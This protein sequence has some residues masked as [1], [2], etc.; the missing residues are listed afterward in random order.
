MATAYYR[1]IC[2]VRE[3]NQLIAER[4]IR[5][6][7]SGT[8]YETWYTPTRYDDPLVAQRELALPS[9]II[10]EYRVGPIPEGLIPPLSVG[11]RRSAPAFGHPGGGIEIAT[12]EPVWLVG[13][14]SFT[15]QAFD[16]SL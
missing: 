1:H 3:R 14:W 5:S 12:K 15:N 16:S 7:N 13:L 2:D 4:K 8:G 10:P 11:P 9:P 6:T